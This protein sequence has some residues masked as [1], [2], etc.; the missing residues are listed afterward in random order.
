[1]PLTQK[2]CCFLLVLSFAAANLRAQDKLNPVDLKKLSIEELMN[3]RSNTCI[4][5]TGETF[6]GCVSHPGNNIRRYTTFGSEHAARG[7]TAIT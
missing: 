2:S 5:N 1:M 4:Q 3:P 6:P 7:I